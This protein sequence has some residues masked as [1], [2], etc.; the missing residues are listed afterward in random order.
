MSKV[1]AV[2][3]SQSHTPTTF[4]PSFL[5][6]RSL[7]H[8]CETFTALSCPLPF[9]PSFSNFEF[10]FDIS[11]KFAS[12]R[13]STNFKSK[14][15]YCH[16]WIWCKFWVLL[17]YEFRVR[18]KEEFSS[19]FKL[20]FFL[21]PLLDLMWVLSSSLMQVLSLHQRGIRLRFWINFFLCHY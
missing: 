8:W 20:T 3:F 1:C 16:C 6:S 21:L 12:K 18:I 13:N 11:S 10:R 9:F 5:L 4:S 19:N 7:F 2:F 15:F 14:F 17:W